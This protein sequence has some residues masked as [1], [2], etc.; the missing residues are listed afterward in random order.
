[1]RVRTYGFPG[2][3]RGLPEP[4]L[5]TTPTTDRVEAC[6]PRGC[7][8]CSSV[9][10]HRSCLVGAQTHRSHLVGAQTHRSRLVGAQT[11]RARLV[12]VQKKTQPPRSWGSAPKLRTPSPSALPR[13]PPRRQVHTHNRDTPLDAK[14]RGP[15][16]PFEEP[17][18]LTL[19]PSGRVARPHTSL[20][21]LFGGSVPR[22]SP[23]YADLARDARAFHNS[24]RILREKPHRS[25]ARTSSIARTAQIAVP[26]SRP[27]IPPRARARGR[28]ALLFRPRGRKATPLA[29]DRNVGLRL[30]SS[31]SS[32]RAARGR[33]AAA[34]K[35]R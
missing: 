33:N 11:R 7:C 3:L 23:T 4:R 34:S 30:R 19:R 27:E 6:R 32:S 9:A 31:S 35:Q 20:A 22:L 14:R 13:P 17:F 21:S 2:D 24:F 26:K 15:G 1:V 10:S 16:P 18:Q 5:A 25:R 29:R 12:G 8:C 28:K